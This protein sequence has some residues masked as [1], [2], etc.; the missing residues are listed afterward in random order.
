MCGRGVQSLEPHV[1]MQ[2][3]EDHLQTLTRPSCY[4]VFL[5]FT[6]VVTGFAGNFCTLLGILLPAPSKFL[7]FKLSKIF[8]R[9]PS[10]S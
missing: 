7:P 5:R 3:S 2:R 10:R 8:T 1:H 9:L 6:V 4:P